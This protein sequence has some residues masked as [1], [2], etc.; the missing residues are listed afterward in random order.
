MKKEYI[1]EEEKELLYN[2]IDKFTD[3]VKAATTLK[4]EEIDEL[5][6]LVEGIYE[7]EDKDK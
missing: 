7:K 2:E 3:E 4:K 5:I 1:N 6:N